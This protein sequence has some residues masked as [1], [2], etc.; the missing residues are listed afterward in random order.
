M[1]VPVIFKDYCKW[2]GNQM[3]L[4][5]NQ[6]NCIGCK[7]CELSCSAA[8]EDVFNP[9]LGRLKVSSSYENGELLITGNICVLC[10]D[11]AESCPT[12][13]IVMEG[14]RLHYTKEDCID[15]GICVNACPENVIVQKGV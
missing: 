14:G 6:Q 13:A 11:C 5:F 7:L 10:G 8:H 2:G 1:P 4:T 12:G 15:C 9:K 3:G